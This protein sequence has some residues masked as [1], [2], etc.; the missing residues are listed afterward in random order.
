MNNRF[1]RVKLI[2]LGKIL[3]IG[4]LTYIGFLLV[5]AYLVDGLFQD[6]AARILDRLGIYHW[7]QNHKDELLTLGLIAAEL[8]AVYSLALSAFA[9]YLEE[10]SSAVNQVFEE[11]SDP[12]TLPGELRSLEMQ[13]NSIQLSMR[14]RRVEALESEQRKNDMVVYLAHDLKTPLTS[15]TGYLALLDEAKDLPEAQREKYLG[16]AYQKALKLE[17]LANELFDLTRFN[18]QDISLT[19]RSVNLPLLFQQLVEEF[20]PLLEKRSL[21]C[22]VDSQDVRH[23]IGDS[24]K[25]ARVFDNLLRNAVFYAEPGTE[26]V[27]R[28]DRVEMG[29]RIVFGNDGVTIPPDKLERIFEQFYRVET[30]RSGESGGAG[31]GLAIAR[32]IVEKHGGSI[33]A[34]SENLHT[35]FVILLPQDRP[36][37][38]IHIDTARA[39]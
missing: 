2:L 35:E 15:V 5:S 39:E 12:A 13:L 37:T 7:A 36:D 32:R 25:L 20:Y 29:V 34:S 17:T 19:L 14:Q 33:T 1:T 27:I 38:Q 22:R 10:I 9:G 31:L 11:S 6:M 23:I 28:V 4:I 18:I 16:I 24:D 30:A 26:I 21:R 8:L 3:L